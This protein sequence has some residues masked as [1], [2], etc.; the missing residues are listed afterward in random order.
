[1]SQ[2]VHRSLSCSAAHTGAKS[3]P[4]RMELIVGHCLKILSAYLAARRQPFQLLPDARKEENMNKIMPRCI[5]EPSWRAPAKQ[6]KRE[7]K[8]RK[9]VALRPESRW[10]ELRSASATDRVTPIVR[11]TLAAHAAGT[12]VNSSNLID[13]IWLLANAQ[14]SSSFTRQTRVVSNQIDIATSF[15]LAIL[16]RHSCSTSGG[17]CSFEQGCV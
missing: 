11:T 10:V 1:M 3:L 5:D 17:G 9:C 4:P 12:R 14:E 13:A 16:S 6:T 15:T 8:W 2:K 7:L